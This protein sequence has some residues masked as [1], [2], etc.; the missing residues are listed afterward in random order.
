LVTCIRTYR[1]LPVRSLQFPVEL[2]R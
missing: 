1:V 2:D